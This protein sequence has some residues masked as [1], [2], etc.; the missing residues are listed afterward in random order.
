MLCPTGILSIIGNRY[1][2]CD[3]D[4]MSSAVPHF[5]ATVMDGLHHQTM[6]CLCQ[7]DYHNMRNVMNAVGIA[8]MYYEP[9]H[10]ESY[11]KNDKHFSHTDLI[12]TGCIDIV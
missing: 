6:S 4:T 1:S 2:H 9:S 10:L 7:V 5:P 12:I 8:N 3:C 11:S